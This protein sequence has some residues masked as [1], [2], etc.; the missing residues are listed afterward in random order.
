LNHLPDYISLRPGHPDFLDLPWDLPL[1]CWREIC[2][3]IEEVERGLSRHT[4][5]FVNYDGILYALKE[6]PAG[7]SEK[8]YLQLIQMENL[9]LPAVTPVGYSVTETLK[10]KASV[11]I[12][13]YLDNSLPFR[14][15]SFKAI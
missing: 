11:L 13:K 9:R 8:E 14:S 4:V 12:T 7:Q 1:D 6:L 3:R 15:L 10:G 2:Y 5:V